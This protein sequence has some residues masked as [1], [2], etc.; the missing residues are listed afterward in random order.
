M[1]KNAL[2]FTFSGV[3]QIKASYDAAAELLIVS[4]TDSGN[5]IDPVEQAKLLKAFSKLSKTENMN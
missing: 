2:K 4:V 1:T 5:G 3:I